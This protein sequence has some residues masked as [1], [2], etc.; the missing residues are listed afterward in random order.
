MRALLDINVI[1]DFMAIRKSYEDAASVMNLAMRRS[2]HAY[3]SAHEITTLSYF[4]EK[5][6]RFRGTFREK[7]AFL[8]EMVRVLPVDKTALEEALVSKMD[9]FEDAV[10]E[11]LSLRENLDC[12][13]TH[14]ISDFARSRIPAL[15]PSAFLKRMEADQKGFT[16]REPA[17]SYR[18]RPRRRTAKA[19]KT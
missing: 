1:L 2:F 9:D 4:L 11:S 12:I 3:V 17:P 18:S 10:L 13:V 15:T 5:D 16:L 8:L 19:R 6:R 7:I 14:N